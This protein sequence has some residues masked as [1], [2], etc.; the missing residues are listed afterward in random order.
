MDIKEI[1]NF[2]DANS[3]EQIAKYCNDLATNPTASNIQELCNFLKVRHNLMERHEIIE[4]ISLLLILI[5]KPGIQ[6]LEDTIKSESENVREAMILETLFQASKGN[7]SKKWS[8]T[9]EI[10]FPET[11]KPSE[12]ISQLA[13]KSFIDI[14]IV[15]LKAPDLFFDLVQFIYMHTMLGS[16]EIDTSIFKI[17]AKSTININESILNEY[18]GKI[19]ADLPEE[20]YQ[21][22]LENNPCLIDPLASVILNKAKLGEELITDFVIK[23]LDNIYILVEIERPNT[24]IFTENND[25][26]A[27][28]SHAI[29]QIMDF[30]EWVESNIAYAQRKMPF[31]SSPQGLLIIG[32]KNKL[33]SKQKSKLNRFNIS[34]RGRITV[35]A[36]DEILEQ[37]RI[38]LDN[39]YSR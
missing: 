7:F 34:T 33:S 12:E 2:A 14:V 39:I 30:Q 6:A 35:S 20:A 21:K 5:G 9:G 4:H 31:I 27:P 29:G 22:F 8:V 28:F 23:R 36:F 10:S 16:G 24:E 38:Y 19:Q 13:Y 37:G 26:C 1:Q 25:F 17:I 18:E 11:L 15:S 3:F 32:M